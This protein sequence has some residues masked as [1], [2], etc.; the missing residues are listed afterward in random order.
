MSCRHNAATPNLVTP[1]QDRNTS[2]NLIEDYCFTEPDAVKLIA[3]QDVSANT[4]GPVNAD[5][6]NGISA[7]ATLFLRMTVP[8]WDLQLNAGARRLIFITF[9]NMHMSFNNI[10]ASILMDQQPIVD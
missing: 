10:T 8:C 1:K 3:C 4:G 6:G 2:I 5:S 7:R 9:Q